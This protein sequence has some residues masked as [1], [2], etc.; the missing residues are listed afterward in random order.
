MYMLFAQPREMVFSRSKEGYME[1]HFVKND[2]VSQQ[3]KAKLFW[4]FLDAQDKLQL[5]KGI[6]IYFLYYAMI[7]YNA[8]AK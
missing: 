1:L 7:R 3:E 4:K 2:S 6:S 8:R 5:Q